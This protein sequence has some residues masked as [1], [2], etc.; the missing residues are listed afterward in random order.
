M[1]T[2]LKHGLLDTIQDLGRYGYQ[3]YGV[4]ASG[5][6]DIWAHRMANLLVGNEKHASTIEMTVVGPHLQFEKDSV[7][8]LCGA[9]LQPMMD[10]IPV[11][12]WRPVFVKK[13]SILQL[14]HAIAGSRAYLA[15]AG[16]FVIPKVI[17]S[18]STYLRAKIGGL[19]GRAL[20]RG[21]QIAINENPNNTSILIESFKQRQ[22]R[23]PFQTTNWFVAPSLVPNNITPKIIH[24][25]K[26]KQYDAFTESTKRAFFSQP[27]TVSVNSDRMGYRLTGPHLTLSEP[28]EMISEAVSFGS[29]QVPAD[30]NPIILTADR[31]T[32]GGYPKIAQVS[33]CDFSILAQAKP[34]DKLLFNMIS[35]EASQKRYIQMEEQFRQ[36]T[37]A[38]RIT[39]RGN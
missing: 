32:T 24:V 36:L 4:V 19:E 16:G 2:I 18:Q 17:S 1:L 5:A 26:G 27:F 22:S 11:P 21:D 38:L 14:G 20:K 9:N 10:G 35:I 3:K 8:A 34:G 31:Q 12:M 30:G 13:N 25:T 7:F 37:M 28:K 6:M 33:S 23:A 15:V 29:I 39:L